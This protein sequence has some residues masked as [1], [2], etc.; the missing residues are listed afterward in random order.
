[1]LAKNNHDDGD[2]VFI[3]I[4]VIK[5]ICYCH[6]HTITT[7]IFPIITIII[8]I[9]EYKGIVMMVATVMV[10]PSS[11]AS[12]RAAAHGFLGMTLNGFR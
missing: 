12:G 7:I 11:P 5:R 1:M 6:Y 9:Q 8:I 3:L 10:Y 2:A 4:V